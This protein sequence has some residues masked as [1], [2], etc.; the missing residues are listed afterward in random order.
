[1]QLGPWKIAART[2]EELKLHK[3][4]LG[5]RGKQRRARAASSL[6]GG[7]GPVGEKLEEGGIDLGVRSAAGLCRGGGSPAAPGRGFRADEVQHEV[8]KLVGYPN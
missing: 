7:E 8:G 5:Q 4:A 1:M 2:L 6:A 3:N